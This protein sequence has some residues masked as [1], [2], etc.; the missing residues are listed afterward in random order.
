MFRSIRFDADNLGQ[1]RQ[2]LDKDSNLGSGFCGEHHIIRSYRVF[3]TGD[4]GADTNAKRPC[5]RPPGLSGENGAP[6]ISASFSRSP[7]VTVRA[8]GPIHQSSDLL[9]ARRC[10]QG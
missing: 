7:A 2:Y 10:S 5:D 6:S 8:L 9:Q 3:D 1:G 4:T